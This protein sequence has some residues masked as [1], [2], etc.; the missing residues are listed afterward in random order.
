MDAE[1]YSRSIALMCPT[2]GHK[3]FERDGKDDAPLRCVGCDR[4]FT[5]EELIQENGEVI[6]AEVDEVKAEVLKDVTQEMRNMFKKAFSG[7]K[8]IRFK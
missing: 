8:H 4:R 2:C 3:D 7:S 1:K 5:R 6:A